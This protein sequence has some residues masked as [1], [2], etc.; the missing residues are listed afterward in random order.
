MNLSNIVHLK[1]EDDAQMVL[2]PDAVVLPVEHRSL[3][4]LHTDK[5][6]QR[7]QSYL[8]FTAC[9]PRDFVCQGTVL[10]QCTF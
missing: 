3:G 7:P 2:P 9:V 4:R 5:P 8:H 6:S 10:H 1:W